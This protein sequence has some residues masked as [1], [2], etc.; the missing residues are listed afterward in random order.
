M[1]ALVCHTIFHIVL[2]CK[3]IIYKCVNV[4][5]SVGN[6]KSIPILESD[7]QG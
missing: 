3:I 1:Y 6:Q 2:Y 4:T 5:T 7:T